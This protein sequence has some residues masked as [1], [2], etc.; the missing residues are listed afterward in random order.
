[1]NKPS[2]EEINSI[3]NLPVMELFSKV[4]QKSGN[5]L[6][7]NIERCA[8][9]SVKTGRCTEDCAYCAQSIR[10]KTDIQEHDL[11][12]KDKVVE[13]AKRAKEMGATNFCLSTAGRGI[14]SEE[15]FEKI[16]EMIEIISKEIKVCCTFGLLTKEKAKRLK[17]AGIHCY[18]HNIDTGPSFYPKIIT[19]RKFEDRLKTIDLL[20]DENIKVC[21]GGILGMG[22]ADS[23]RIEF[24]HSLCS[25][26]KP[27]Y[28]ISLNVL[29]PMKGTPLE[30]Q[31]P[32]PILDLVRIIA[33]L[34]I[35]LPTSIIRF[36]GGR[37]FY[38]HAEQILC[39]LAGLGSI[40]IGEKLL[41]AKNC[42][43]KDDNI[44]EEILKCR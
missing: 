30:G 26:R 22:E 23:D 31:K 43:L 28:S 35:L 33:T 15:D 3:Y 37:S 10:Y 20:I 17:N 8:L 1:M 14:Y 19:T 38:S 25:M 24:I 4:G 29:I 5:C 13:A 6:C 7:K 39:F 34:K 36:A 16:E 40:H 27:P 9:L 44:L 32:L 42:S 41:T 12:N 18:N 11:L 2:I 21:S